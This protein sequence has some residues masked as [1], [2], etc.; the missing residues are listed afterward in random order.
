M[1]RASSLQY[2]QLRAP[3]PAVLTR[4]RS[5]LC[6]EC[7]SSLN[8]VRRRFIDR[9]VSLFYPVH[10][11]HCRSFVCNWEG[12]LRDTA[13]LGRWEAL[14]SYPDDGSE[15]VCGAEEQAATATTAKPPAAVQ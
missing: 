10:R 7:G 4:P 12:N 8:R 2:S 9:V 5:P 1:F 14:G 6:P 13:A 11:Y 3:G 15:S